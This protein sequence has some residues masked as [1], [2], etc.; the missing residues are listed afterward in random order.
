MDWIELDDFRVHCIIGVLEREQR[1]PQTLEFAIRL[2]LDLRPAAGGD[3]SR[4]VNYAE[5]ADQAE[6]LAKTGRWRLLES[7]GAA[8]CQLVLSKPAPLEARAQVEQ[9]EV[10]MR[11]PEILGEQATP[12]VRLRRQA[13]QHQA[14][15]LSLSSGTPVDVLVETNRRGAYRLHLAGGETWVLPAGAAAHLI[16]GEGCVKGPK[17][18]T[19]PI[20]AGEQLTSGEGADLVCI[21]TGSEPL[22]F[23]VVGPLLGLD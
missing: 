7:L 8:I 22:T 13:G 19:R 2:G 14:Q 18:A 3:L 21:N 11:K 17:E 6:F 4:S 5:V 23:L 10:L 12:A 1:E 20:F 15:R 16:A 9:I